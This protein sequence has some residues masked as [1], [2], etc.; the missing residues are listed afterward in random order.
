MDSQEPT[1]P[2]R[3]LYIED[4]RQNI[5]LMHALMAR[6]DHLSLLVSTNAQHGIRIASSHQPK[7]ILMDMNLPGISG[8]EAL[9]LL[10]AQPTTAH[11]PVIALSSGAY[12]R[13]PDVG[14][15]VGFA[16]YLSK[17]FRLEDLMQAIDMVLADKALDLQG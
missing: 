3:I 13:H 5:A 17:P 9:H 7:L 1:P 15:E 11:I 8:L 2:H 10:Q 14:A 12:P 6:F 16:A 4:N